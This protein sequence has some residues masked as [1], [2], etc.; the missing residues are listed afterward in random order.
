MKNTAKLNCFGRIVVFPKRKSQ[1]QEMKEEQNPRRQEMKE[2]L[3]QVALY[4]ETKERVEELR[5]LINQKRNSIQRSPRGKIHV[6]LNRNTLQFYLRKN[7]SDT[8]GEYISKKKTK[9]ISEYLQKEYDCAFVKLAEEELRV[10]EDVLKQNDKPRKLKDIYSNKDERLKKYIIPVDMSDED[11]I[12]EWEKFKFTPKTF[13]INDKTE[14]YTEKGE[15]VRSKSEINIANLLK[16][17]GIPYRYECPLKLKNGRI[18]HPDFTTLNVR[19]RR[20]CYWEHRGKMDSYDYANR[21]VERIKDYQNN[22]IFL[23]DDLIITEETLSHQLG[24]KEIQKVIDH[25]LR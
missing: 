7:P 14:Y 20:V 12:T 6:I 2:E 1:R 25:F 17:N 18:I 3:K 4:D 10:L 13:D 5:T 23:G 15:R 21:S 19:K 22:G 9:L 16:K 8:P 24:T 11:Y